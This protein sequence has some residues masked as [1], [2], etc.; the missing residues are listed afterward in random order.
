MGVISFENDEPPRSTLVRLLD[1]EEV[2]VCAASSL[3]EKRVADGSRDRRNGFVVDSRD[4]GPRVALRT[5]RRPPT[6]QRRHAYRCRHVPEW[7][8]A[9]TENGT[10]G[11]VSRS[12][13]CPCVPTDTHA[14][15]TQFLAS[16]SNTL[17]D[18]RFVLA[19]VMV[20]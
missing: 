5:C 17:R 1:T 7:D 9:A 18:S 13:P 19:A 8:S 11:P 10:S 15:P 16:S 2:E 12:L 6:T 14:F 3:G 20:S 4:R